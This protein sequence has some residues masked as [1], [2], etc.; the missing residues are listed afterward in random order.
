[1]AEARG[2]DQHWVRI[3]TGRFH[4]PPSIVQ[5]VC[6]WLEQGEHRMQRTVRP[7]TAATI[8]LALAAG[9]A[10]YGQPATPPGEKTRLDPVVDKILTRLE[11]REV[12]D[13]RAK[14]KWELTYVVEEEE[15]ADR[16]LGTLWYKEGQPVAKFKVHFDRK[17]VGNTARELDE[18]HL[19]DGRWYVELQ[20]R[21]KTV[22]RREIR[23]EGETNN[24]YK[25]GE[26]A[27]PLPFGQK[28]ADILA[29]FEVERIPERKDDPFATD[30]LKLT[31][32]PNTK[33]GQ[34]YKTLGFWVAR[35]GDHS[36]LPVKVVAGKKDGTGA[37]NSY[38]TVTFSEIELNS[39]F[40]DSVFKIEVPKGYEEVIER[41][42]TA[43]AP[44]ETAPPENRP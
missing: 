4:L 17:I 44:P 11:K 40:S 13:L 27:F 26:G 24:P 1:V 6:T 25:L 14:V 5:S 30:H 15:D 20:A 18:Q 36:G 22:T 10:G 35:E 2:N 9:V 3:E 7:R 23:R 42:E 31:P 29:E 21:T 28:K 32:R 34:S 41:L 37:V 43:E 12:H 39:G 8:V 38:I 33:T 19:F 16:K